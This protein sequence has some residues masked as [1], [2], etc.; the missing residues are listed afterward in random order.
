MRCSLTLFLILCI[1]LPCSL[2]AQEEIGGAPMASF[3]R[4]MAIEDS[5]MEQSLT[6]ALEE[7]ETD[8]WKDQRN[9]ENSLKQENYTAYKTYIFYKRRAYL[10]HNKNCDISN[11]HG[12]GYNKQASFY[13]VQGRIALASES[14]KVDRQ[15]LPG[16]RLVSHQ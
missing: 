11:E 16:G 1:C 4:S 5:L 3:Y 10:E 9:F 7:D 6:F 8:F 15:G 14:Q 2:S 12:K 13:S